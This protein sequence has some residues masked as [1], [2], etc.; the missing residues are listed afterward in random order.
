MSLRVAFVFV[1]S[2][3]GSGFTTGLSPVQITAPPVHEMRSS[4]SIPMGNRPEGLIRKVRWSCPC[5]RPWRPIGFWDVEAPTLSRQSAMAVRLW[6]LRVGRRLPPGRFLVLIS[7]RG[8]RPQGHSA[9]GRIRSIVKLQ[10][11]H[12]ES[13]FRLVA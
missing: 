5:N 4:R 12:R 3:V 2:Y 1:L 13:T 9:A 10:W 6:A 11:P 8:C 7:V